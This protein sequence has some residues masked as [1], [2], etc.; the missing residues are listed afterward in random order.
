MRIK[1]YIKVIAVCIWALL[2]CAIIVP[3]VF[4]FCCALK[5][6]SRIWE[7]FAGFGEDITEFAKIASESVDDFFGDIIKATKCAK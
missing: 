2:C 4:V 3:I 1:K 7:A 6:I 5:L